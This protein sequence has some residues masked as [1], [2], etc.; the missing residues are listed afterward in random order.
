MFNTAFCHIDNHL[1]ETMDGI[2]VVS[3]KKGTS[4]EYGIT[5]G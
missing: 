2:T 3:R 1:S 5:N 4:I